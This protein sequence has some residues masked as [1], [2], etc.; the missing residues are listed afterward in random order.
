MFFG[1]CFD[2]CSLGAMLENLLDQK[3]ITE[4]CKAGPCSH[5][6]LDNHR[7][8]S[9]A[10]P[11]GGHSSTRCGGSELLTR[12]ICAWCQTVDDPV[13]SCN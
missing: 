10:N 4:S 2:A 7:F 3:K 5:G 11:V 13:S 12:V 6:S 1:L 9:H 8:K